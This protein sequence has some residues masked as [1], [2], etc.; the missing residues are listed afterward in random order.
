M[1]KNVIV[2]IILASAVPLTAV[3]VPAF[4]DA[5]ASSVKTD[6]GKTVAIGSDLTPNEKEA[7]FRYFGITDKNSVRVIYVT[8]KDERDHLSSYIPLE[9]IGNYTVSCAYINPTQTGGIKVRTAN[10]LYVTSNMIASTLSTSGV[11]NCEVIAACPFQV[12]GTGALTGII[13]AYENS[14]GV[15]LDETKKNIATQEVV[16][17]ES[18]AKTAGTVQAENIVNQA[19]IKAVQDNITDPK[20]IQQ[21]IVNIANDNS[22]NITNE[23][24]NNTTNVIQQIVQQKYPDDYLE[25]LKKPKKIYTPRNCTKYI[26]FCTKKRRR[27][28]QK[29]R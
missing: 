15:K 13:M 3:S 11:T 27:L 10:L 7:I 22:V 26:I 5:I 1:R 20:E 12:S 19:K 6:M 9:Q 28:L 4:A 17:T 8:N 29:T 14:T 16:A 21:T 2:P 23:Q 24:V 18:I 25:T